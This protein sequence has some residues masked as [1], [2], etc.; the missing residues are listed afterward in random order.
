MDTA[1]DDDGAAA[2]QSARKDLII[3]IV[4]AINGVF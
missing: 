4:F 1:D 3:G 2:R